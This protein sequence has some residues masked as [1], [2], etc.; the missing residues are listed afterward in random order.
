MVSRFLPA[1]TATVSTTG[2]PTL[3]AATRCSLSRSTAQAATANVLRA[4]AVASTIVVRVPPG[5]R[6]TCRSARNTPT[7][8]RVPVRENAD[9]QASGSS[10]EAITAMASPSS[11][12]TSRPRAPCRAD[13]ICPVTARS[14][15][16]AAAAVAR[17]A[18]ATQ[19]RPA[20]LRPDRRHSSTTGRRSVRR[21]ASTTASRPPAVASPAAAQAS[22]GSTT[23]VPGRSRTRLSAAVAAHPA[24]VPTGRARASSSTGSD[25]PNTIVRQPPRP[26]SLAR[27]TSC[28]RASIAS[29]TD[30]KSSSRQAASNCAVIRTTGI[31]TARQLACTA[32][33]VA[34]MPVVTST[35]CCCSA[36]DVLKAVMADASWGTSLPV[37]RDWFS[38]S[39][40]TAVPCCCGEACSSVTRGVK[41]ASTGLLP[42]GSR[43]SPT[44]K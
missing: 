5:R 2:A 36:G 7:L 22:G 43:G 15:R 1:G 37:S 3:A 6:A 8:P 11:P 14:S 25:I 19:P 33:S 28:P 42:E 18:S 12:G 30:R 16:P 26:R 32:W 23:A 31:S 39:S 35:C 17:T 40:T 29:V 44:G 10:R 21:A 38:R 34:G 41:K 24:S 13:P 27:D 4:N 20:G 9:R